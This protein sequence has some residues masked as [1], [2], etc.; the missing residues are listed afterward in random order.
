MNGAQST[1]IMNSML[2]FIRQ[3]GN[4]RVAEIKRQTQEDFVVQK[5]QLIQKEKQR[6]T[7]QFNKDLSIAEIN[8]KIEKSAEQNK[9]RIERMKAINELVEGLQK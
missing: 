1:K 9:E 7:N 8:L 4:E 5:E 2:E 6:L 3:H